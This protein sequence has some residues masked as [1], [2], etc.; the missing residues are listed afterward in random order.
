ML[1][2]AF[3]G[4]GNNVEETLR[5]LWSIDIPFEPVWNIISLSVALGGVTGV[6]CSFGMMIIGRE[7]V[8]GLLSSG[9]VGEMSRCC[10]E[11]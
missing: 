10:E 7:L 8:E 9:E 6:A 11:E 3:V 5:Y 1:E 2:F 4:E